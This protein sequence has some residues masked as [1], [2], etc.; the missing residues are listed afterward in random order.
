[1][2]STWNPGC[3]EEGPRGLALDSARQFLFVA[4]TDGVRVLDAAHGG[5]TIASLKRGR[6]SISSTTSRRIIC[7]TLAQ[8]KRRASR[9]CVWTS[10]A[11]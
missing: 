11:S 8:E 5:A 9:W 6:E 4:C 7:S 10:E 3:G 2:K 1:V